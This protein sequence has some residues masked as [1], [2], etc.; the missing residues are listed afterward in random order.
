MVSD[1]CM[2]WS[3]CMPE[4]WIQR[5]RKVTNVKAAMTNRI[6]PNV[7]A[8]ISWGEEGVGMAWI[9]WGLGC[10][11][12]CWQ[13]IGNDENV[14]E[15]TKIPMDHDIP[16][17]TVMVCHG[18][19]D[20]VDNRIPQVTVTVCHSMAKSDTVTKIPR[21]HPHL[22]YTLHA[23]LSQFWLGGLWVGCWPNR[24]LG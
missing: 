1:G 6:E 18:V 19:A 2:T 15:T 13:V 17:V 7:G 16:W 12:W 21:C 4:E 14:K 24:R 9:V 8:A 5:M 22:G 11:R 20:T 3:G 10:W 23:W